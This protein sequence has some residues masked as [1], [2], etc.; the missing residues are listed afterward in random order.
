MKNLS[1]FATYSFVLAVAIASLGAVMYGI[2]SRANELLYYKELNKQRTVLFYN[3]SILCAGPK[4]LKCGE[5]YTCR[6]TKPDTN[7]YGK[8][9][10]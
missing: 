7:A 8:C 9:S 10:T 5:G 6:I 1:G 3:A 2:Q 4:S